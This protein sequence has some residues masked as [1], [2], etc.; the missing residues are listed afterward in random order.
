MERMYT[1]KFRIY[2]NKEQQDY[3]A[4]V[5]GCCRLVYNHFLNEKKKQYDETK[6]SD[7]YNVQQSKL[8]KLRKTE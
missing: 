7:L 1:Y 3:L 2:P 8:T 6:T 5:F 4:N